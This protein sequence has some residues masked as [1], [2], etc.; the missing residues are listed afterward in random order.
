MDLVFEKL[1][2]Y[3]ILIGFFVRG[4]DFLVIETKTLKIRVNDGKIEIVELLT[5]KP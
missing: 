5:R 3:F 2:Q 4:K 1:F